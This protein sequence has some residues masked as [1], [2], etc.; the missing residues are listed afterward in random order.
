MMAGDTPVEVWLDSYRWDALEEVLEEQGSSIEKY[1][2]DHLIDLY[3]ELVPHE[4]QMKIDR[5]IQSECIADAQTAAETRRFSAYKVVEGSRWD[6]FETEQEL[7]LL[8]AASRLRRYLRGELPTGKTLADTFSKCAHLDFDSYDCRI[9][10]YMDGRKQIHGVFE[11]NIDLQVFAFLDREKGW[12]QYDLKD[13]STAIYHAQRSNRRQELEVRRIFFERLEGKEWSEQSRRLTEQDVSFSEEIE[14]IDGK[15]NFYMDVIFDPDAVFGTH[16]AT[17]ENDDWIN[18]YANYDMEKRQV[19]GELDIILHKDSG[20]DEE[21]HYKLDDAEKAVLA[22]KMD[23][24]CLTREGM[25]LEQ[26]CGQMLEE[27]DHGPEQ[28]MAPLQ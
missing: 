27:Q 28:G 19:C 21:L 17:A 23:A 6:F 10:E 14:E 1:L 22:A 8:Q 24:Y 3:T 15:L 9:T 13:V 11:I 2:Q 16:V 7:D 25:T 5:L 26:L 12:Q 4:R 20:Q 18:V